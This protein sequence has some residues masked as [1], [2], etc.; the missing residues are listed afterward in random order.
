MRVLSEL[1]DTFDCTSALDCSVCLG[2]R[3]PFSGSSP[4]LMPTI[5]PSFNVERYLQRKGDGRTS[6]ESTLEIAT[7]SRVNARA[8]TVIRDEPA[9]WEHVMAVAGLQSAHGYAARRRAPSYSVTTRK[10]R[11]FC[12]MTRGAEKPSPRR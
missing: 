9:P 1:R 10:P 8:A 6:R 5:D 11:S 7:S 2:S 12:S 3:T 4:F